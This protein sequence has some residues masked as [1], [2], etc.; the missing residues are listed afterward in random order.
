M[1]VKDIQKRVDDLVGDLKTIK[2]KSSENTIHNDNGTSYDFDIQIEAL[3]KLPTLIDDFLRRQAYPN[4]SKD[5]S[6][7]K[8]QEKE[9][10]P[11]QTMLYKL[12]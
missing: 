2:S 3:E 12:V 7:M 9:L 6:Y 8:W 10:T 1:K 4:S 11:H 5:H